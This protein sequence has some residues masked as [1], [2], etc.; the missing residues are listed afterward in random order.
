M[1]ATDQKKHKYFVRREERDRSTY[2]PSYSHAPNC[3]NQNV[4]DPRGKF[5]GVAACGCR[6]NYLGAQFI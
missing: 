1:P 4:L 5:R 6:T 2:T 3:S